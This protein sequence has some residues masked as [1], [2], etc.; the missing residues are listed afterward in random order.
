MPRKLVIDSSTLLAFEKAGLVDLLSKLGLKILVPPSVKAEIEAGRTAVLLSIVEAVQ[1]KGRTIK[2]SRTL[3]NLGIGKGEADCCVLA[4]RLKLGLIICDDRKF[5]R[6]R[7]LSHDKTLSAITIFGFSFLLHLLY[8]RK[9][10]NDVWPLFEKIIS[11]NHWRRSEVEAANY[12][13]LKKM[14]Y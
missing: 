10:V 3:E 5:L 4:T 14:G 9:A 8:K 11:A 7:F 13:F 1:L 12:A 2:K 6:Q